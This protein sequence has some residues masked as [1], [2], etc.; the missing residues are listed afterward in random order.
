MFASAARWLTSGIVDAVI[1]GGVDSLCLSIIHGFHSLQLVSKQLCRPFDQ[2]RDGINLGEAAGFALLMRDAGEALP[3]N[4]LGYGESCDAYHMS[5][6]HPDGLGAEFAMRAA[7]AR[8]EL[9]FDDIGYINMHGT[10][11]RSNDDIEARVCARLF[12]ETVPVSSTKGWTGHTLGAAG[13]TEAIISIDALRTNLLPGNLNTEDPEPDIATHLLLENREA[14]ITT[15][16]TNSF[17]FG[18]NNCSLIF[19]ANSA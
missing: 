10:G 11:T 8:S 19:G 9:S 7:I 4:L 13:I 16:M 3:V 14:R 17:G 15:A 6:A 12:P 18:G 2:N 1:V 5:S